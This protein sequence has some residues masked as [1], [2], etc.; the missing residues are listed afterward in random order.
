M[1][2][3]DAVRRSGISIEP[4]RT[5]RDAASIMGQAG[6]GAL[7]IVADD[8]LLGIVTDRDLVRRGLARMRVGAFGPTGGR[9]TSV[10]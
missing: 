4:E 3:I 7:A 10:Y 5:I 9:R 1:Q 8:R 6:V 2:S